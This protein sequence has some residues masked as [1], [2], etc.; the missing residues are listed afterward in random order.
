VHLL[1]GR[2]LPVGRRR[3]FRPLLA[4]AFGLLVATGALAWA[5]HAQRARESGNFVLVPDL[6]YAMKEKP[7][8]GGAG[9]VDGV[10]PPERIPGKKRILCV[11]DSVTE[12]AGVGAPSSWP[13]RLQDDLG[14]R[15]TEVWNFG[16][17]G[18]D[19]SQVAALVTTRLEAWHP[20][21]VIWGTYA[22]DIFPTYVVVA[23]GSGDRV[24]LGTDVP[25]GASLLPSPLAAWLLPRS[26]LFRRAQAAAWLRMT[27]TNPAHP[28]HGEWY[29]A[30]VDRIE[31][32]ERSTGIPVLIA[33]I[34][35]H[36]IT[37]PC[38]R[39]D[40][41]TFREWHTT[42]TAMLAAHATHWVDTEPA[43]EGAG[44]FY[45]PNSRDPDHPSA[46]GHTRLAAYIAPLAAQL[47]ATPP[48]AP[49]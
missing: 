33:A 22:N 32:W 47:L 28:D 39:S 9:W 4:L 24:F 21:L 17:N 10:T 34:P 37:G 38:D 5:E 42:V 30:Q 23:A 12:G 43:W 25:E 18:W 27:E 3:G 41:A 35:P 2:D 45:Q 20:D 7:S 40:C 8:R 36:V 13:A 46:E 29:A 16:V 26:A 11:G 31:A 14:R 1:H 48:G 15:A 19:A 44:P 49:E 6:K